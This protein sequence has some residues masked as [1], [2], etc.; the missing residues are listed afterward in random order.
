MAELPRPGGAFYAFIEVPPRLGMTGTQFAEAALEH[1]LLVVPGAVFSTRD[2]HFRI[3]Y[4]V[5]DEVLDRGL[6]VLERM[7]GG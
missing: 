7:L 4:A 3:S 5:A 1:G 2:T 6:E